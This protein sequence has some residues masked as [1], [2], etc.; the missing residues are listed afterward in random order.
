MGAIIGTSIRLTADYLLKR[1][2]KS[3]QGILNAK[4]RLFSPLTDIV[5]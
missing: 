2:T 4:K 5:L 1:L 3:P